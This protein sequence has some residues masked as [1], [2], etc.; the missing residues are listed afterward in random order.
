MLRWKRLLMLFV[1]CDRNMAGCIMINF[2]RKGGFT[3][4]SVINE[5]NAW[6]TVR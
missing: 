6:K 1:K 3:K 5:I 4:E 2:G